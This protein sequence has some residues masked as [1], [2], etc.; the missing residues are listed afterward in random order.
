MKNLMKDMQNGMSGWLPSASVIVCA[1]PIAFM[2]H[3]CL[4]A[5]CNVDIQTAQTVKAVSFGLLNQ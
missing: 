5:G 1:S 2:I 3:V 4:I